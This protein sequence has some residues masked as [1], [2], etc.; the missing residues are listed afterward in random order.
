MITRKRLCT[1]SP[2][3]DAKPS[4]SRRRGHLLSRAGAAA[5]LVLAAMAAAGTQNAWALLGTENL[6]GGAGRLFESCQSPCESWSQTFTKE[7]WEAIK[8]RITGT[9]VD[10]GAT[11][12]TAE[13]VTGDTAKDIEVS[14]KITTKV[15]ELE[16]ARGPN[17]AA[18]A[19]DGSI[20]DEAVRIGTLP[21]RWALLRAAGN[22][23]LGVTAF[24]VG[25]KIGSAIREV[26]GF[27]ATDTEAEELIHETQS[28]AAVCANSGEG[29][30]S[31]RGG[32]TKTGFNEGSRAKVPS[33]AI[34][35]FYHS[36]YGWGLAREGFAGGMHY[37][38]KYW[39]NPWEPVPPG[40]FESSTSEEAITSGACEGILPSAAYLSEASFDA[41]LQEPGY[42]NAFTV[43]APAAEPAGWA[44][45]SQTFTVGAPAA[46]ESASPSLNLVTESTPQAVAVVV[47]ESSDLP[48]HEKTAEVLWPEIP[49]PLA[50]ETYNHYRQRLSREGFTS[51]EDSPDIEGSAEPATDQIVNATPAPGTHVNPESLSTTTVVV[52]TAPDSASVI[53]LAE[54]WVELN[55]GN[56]LAAATQAAIE[57]RQIVAARC[58]Q[59]TAE[60][61]SE[62]S[63]CETIPIFFSG[64]DVATAT[65]HDLKALASHPQWVQLNY[66]AAASKEERES[67]EWYAGKGGCSTSKPEGDSCDEYPFFATQQGGGKIEPPASLEWINKEDNSK[68]GSNYSGF[69][70]SCKMAERIATSYAFLAI[71]IKPS[72]EIPT[73]RLC[74]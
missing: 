34:A 58:L 64:S 74:N 56:A 28:W 35:V 53:E 20:V 47:G 32:Y 54:K 11:G 2:L 55:A 72:L 10:Y 44:E 31:Y 43:S 60:G 66:E 22:V 16:S 48:G 49:Q 51:Y 15:R 17:A 65:Q 52:H 12:Q 69:V 27:E 61:S 5:M 39:G 13:I 25:W 45:R 23:G 37:C 46:V 29:C 3:T 62:S 70:S 57:T 40:T 59:M 19:F 38:A 21:S 9:A 71:P 42:P 8:R 73:S 67:R 24:E 4:I 41:E 68:Q 63:N 14:G 6:T 30:N 33:D 18:G 7:Q 1:N 50:H 26:L 36:E